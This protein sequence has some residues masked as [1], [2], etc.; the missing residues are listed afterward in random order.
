MYSY[1]DNDFVP[2]ILN[3]CQKREE[4]LKSGQLTN[5]YYRY[6][7]EMRALARKLFAEN[8]QDELLPYLDTDSISVR[9][10]IA[11]LL[12]NYHHDICDKILREIADMKV[13]D[14]LPK[15]LT[16]VV[17]TARFNLKYSLSEEFP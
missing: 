14:G 13:E 8:G 4:V 12:Y 10:D 15:Y 3:C 6:L 5:K 1:S 11:Y 7:N 9:A 17:E 2:K 16:I